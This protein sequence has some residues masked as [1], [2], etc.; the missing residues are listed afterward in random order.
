MYDI[1]VENGLP[2]NGAGSPPCGNFRD[3]ATRDS[4]LCPKS[5][6]AGGFLDTKNRKK[7]FFGVLFAVFIFNQIT[8][9]AIST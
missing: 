2:L 7:H 1:L 3:L 4:C 8:C 5:G 9:S 6:T